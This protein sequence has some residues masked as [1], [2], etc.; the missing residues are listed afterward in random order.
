LAPRGV[1]Q[2]ERLAT[3]LWVTRELQTDDVRAR[4]LRITALKPHVRPGQA[5][6][7]VEEVDAKIVEAAE[8][9]G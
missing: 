8:L 1:A 9:K 6:E 2:L 4:A 7:A 3:A 5:I